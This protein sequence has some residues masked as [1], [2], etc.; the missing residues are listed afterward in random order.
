MRFFQFFIYKPPF[1]AMNV[2][3]GDMSLAFQIFSEIG[4]DMVESFVEGY[5]RFPT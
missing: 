1:P 4:N 5:T 3:A 2:H